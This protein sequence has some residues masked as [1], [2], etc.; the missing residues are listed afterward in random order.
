M[1]TYALLAV[2]LLLIGLLILVA[3]VFI[4]SGGILGIIT[5]TLLVASLFCAWWA[6]GRGHP[7]VFWSFVVS[8]LVLVP[9]TVIGAFTI[10]PRTP[11]GKVAILEAPSPE[12]LESF[13]GES[14][15]LERYIGR[16]GEAAT[17]LNPG[18]LVVVDGERLHA[19]SDALLVEQH[20]PVR[21]VG[22]QSLRLVVRALSA[23]DLAARNKPSVEAALPP[24]DLDFDLP[25]EPT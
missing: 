8:L 20:Q 13:V 22:V 1:G 21:V 10:L 19:Y 18:G 24:S 14:A 25:D 11:F 15:R 3:E 2:T 6:W 7:T 12:R 23:D 5:T 16:I 9:A 17:V 4:P